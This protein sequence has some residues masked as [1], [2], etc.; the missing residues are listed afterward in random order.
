MEVIRE[1][2]VKRRSNVGQTPVRSRGSSGIQIWDIVDAMPEPGS[3]EWKERAARVL[4]EEL[5][6]PLGWWYLSF[7]GEEGFRGGVYLQARGL[8]TAITAAHALGINPGGEVK[9]MG[10]ISESLIAL[11]VPE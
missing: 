8:T 10:P 11:R 6:E 2:P 3:P 5:G 4:L 1:T 7:A 9:G